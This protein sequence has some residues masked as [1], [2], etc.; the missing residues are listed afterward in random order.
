MSSAQKMK[1]EKLGDSRDLFLSAKV[2]K[3]CLKVN[4]VLKIGDIF[5]SFRFKY[6]VHSGI[7]QGQRTERVTSNVLLGCSEQTKKVHLGR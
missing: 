2:I 3:L 4:V 7:R 5:S 1:P 6:K